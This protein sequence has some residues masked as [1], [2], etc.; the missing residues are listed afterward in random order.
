M[1]GTPEQWNAGSGMD[2]C[3]WL[4]DVTDVFYKLWKLI[5]FYCFDA[6][7]GFQ[8]VPR[9]AALVATVSYILSL[10]VA[11]NDDIVICPKWDKVHVQ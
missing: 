3:W 1:V 6:C 9:C 7:K 2:K 4:T 8:I 5:N 10:E 11:D